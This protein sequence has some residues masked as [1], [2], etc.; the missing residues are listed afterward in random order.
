MTLARLASTGSTRGRDQ[1]AKP[2]P[3]GAGAVA[4]GNQAVASRRRV[5]GSGKRGNALSVGR[6]RQAEAHGQRDQ[7]RH[8]GGAGRPLPVATDLTI[9]PNNEEQFITTG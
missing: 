4:G 6:L 2:G 3:K 5:A 7:P 9:K 1:R 8:D